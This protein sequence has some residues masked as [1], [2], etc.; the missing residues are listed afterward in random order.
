MEESVNLKFINELHDSES[1]AW[2]VGILDLF[3]EFTF[4]YSH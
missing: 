4:L 3:I 2:R 1:L